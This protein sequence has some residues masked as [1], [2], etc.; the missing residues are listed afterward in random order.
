[1]L[2]RS[3]PG[4]QLLP[5]RIW[6]ILALLCIFVVMRS[7]SGGNDSLLQTTSIEQRVLDSDPPLTT[8]ND[9]GHFNST[10]VTSVLARQHKHRD[11]RCAINFFGLPRAFESLV[12]PSI[13]KNIVAVNPGC[14]YFVH[15]YHMTKEAAGRSGAGGFIDP[16]AVLLLRD[17]VHQEARR[18]GNDDD[19][20]PIVEF[21]HDKEK[22]FW[23]R[24]SELIE[25]IRTTRVDGKYLYFPWKETTYKHPDTTDNIVKMWHTIQSSYEL[26]ESVAASKGIE[27]NIVGMFRLDVVYVTPINI[28]DATTTTQQSHP[29]NALVPATIANFG[30]FPVSD[31]MI[32]GPC[33]AVK[34]W[35]TQRFARLDSHVQYMLKQEPGLGMHSERFVYYTLFPLIQNITTIR[36]HPTICFFRAR[37]DE[38]VW[39]SDCSNENSSIAAPSIIEDLLKGNRT[40]HDVVQDAIGRPCSTAKPTQFSAY[41]LSLPCHNVVGTSSDEMVLEKEE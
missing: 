5:K 22:D 14:D 9:G 38:T 23:I 8:N 33:D 26:M 21:V 27:Y 19:E 36:K 15:Y 13:V 24:Y 10:A 37:A 39:V 4:A 16:T 30:N 18:H 3:I 2:S 11:D 20:L 7:L 1:M 6:C 31:R 29:N 12:L 32:Y 35:A 34:A 17:A 25:K 28:R 41:V 40:L